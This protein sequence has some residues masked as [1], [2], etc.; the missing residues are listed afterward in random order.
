M[1]AKTCKHTQTCTHT[2]KG[3]TVTLGCLSITRFMACVVHAEL[4]CIRFE[5]KE[6]RHPNHSAQEKKL[7]QRSVR[8]KREK[9]GKTKKKMGLCLWVRGFN[10][11]QGQWMFHQIKREER[12]REGEREH[13]PAWR[14][15]QAEHCTHCPCGLVNILMKEP[16]PQSCHKLHTDSHND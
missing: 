11:S 4:K 5:T 9:E 6:P 13:G 2:R 7:T 3:N 16:H 10:D 12:G 1:F 15:Q 8:K 14:G